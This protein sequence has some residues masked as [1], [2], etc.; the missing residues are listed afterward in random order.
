MQNGSRIGRH[1]EPHQIQQPEPGSALESPRHPWS[2]PRRGD[3]RHPTFKHRQENGLHHSH[4]SYP[5]PQILRSNR[6]ASH[7]MIRNTAVFGVLR[8]KTQKALLT[9]LLILALSG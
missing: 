8:N 3:G 9:A 7:H 4:P 5:L 1:I 2:R 6:T